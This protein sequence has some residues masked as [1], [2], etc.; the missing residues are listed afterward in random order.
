MATNGEVKNIKELDAKIKALGGVVTIENLEDALTAGGLEIL[1]QAKEN[2]PI[3]SGTLRRSLHI[4]GHTDL[5]ASPQYMS[6]SEDAGKYDD[7][8]KGE[9]QPANVS[10]KIGTNLEYAAPVELGT[11]DRPPNPFLRTAFDGK[12]SAAQIKTREVLIQLVKA[13]ASG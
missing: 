8:G 12:L 9:T 3:I 5:P 13:A 11:E 10:I 4:G 6:V 1:N 2:A 7:I